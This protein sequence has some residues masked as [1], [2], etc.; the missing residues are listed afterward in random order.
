MTGTPKVGA[1]AGKI[2]FKGNPLVT[3]GAAAAVALSGKLILD[4]YEGTRQK[5][6]DNA[7]NVMEHAEWRSMSK[8]WGHWT[9]HPW[10]D[11]LAEKL[12]NLKLFGP[13]SIGIKY[14]QFKSN[15]QSIWQDVISD[16]LLPIAGA[17]AAVYM[18]MGPEAVNKRVKARAGL[19]M[20]RLRSGKPILPPALT[21]PLKKMGKDAADL[22]GRGLVK[23]AKFPFK[24]PTNLFFSI[25][26]L[27]MGSF[28]MDRL[29][30]SM[31][32]TGQASYFRDF[33]NEKHT[34]SEE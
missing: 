26:A 21:G 9:G 11:H 18:A 6:I 30:N 17:G 5:R 20:T 19:I 34:H 28:C 31:T 13:N 10:F 32:H 2:L 14:G 8:F 7:A 1:D 15:V 22:M 16:N 4:S 12:Y 24:N 3:V 23:A 33:I 29:Q 25:G 27:L